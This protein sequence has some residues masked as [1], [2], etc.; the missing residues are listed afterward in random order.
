MKLRANHYQTLDRNRDLKQN[1]KTKIWDL[2]I[3]DKKSAQE[4]GTL[5]NITRVKVNATLFYGKKPYL[6][7]DNRG[8]SPF[9]IKTEYWENEEQ[10]AESLDPKYSIEDIGGKEL[11]WF[12]YHSGQTEIKLSRI[13]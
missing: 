5:L 1:D 10:I 9:G 6:N 13:K 3:H 4:I 2:F 12:M 11:A 8:N 7:L